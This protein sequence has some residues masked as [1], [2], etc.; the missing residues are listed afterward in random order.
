MFSSII[1]V[2]KVN[3][4]VKG[5]SKKTGNAYER[6]SAECVL[7]DS[8]GAIECVGRL[9]I[10]EALRD[11]VKPGH[12]SAGFTLRVPTFG[13]RK[14]D[15]EAALVTLQPLQRAA[16]GSLTIAPPAAPAKAS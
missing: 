12:F 4:V 14:G 1:Q 16:N 8:S 9:V 7:L 5:V 10:P 11:A 15:I 3:E 13:D 6:H 2:L